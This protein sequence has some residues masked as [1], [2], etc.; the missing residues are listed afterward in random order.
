M[1]DERRLRRVLEV[2]RTVV[3]EL[4]LEVVLRRV[5]EVA[6]ELTDAR[7]AALGV[8][9]ADKRELE[10]FI[11]AGASEAMRQE[12]GDLPRG[13]GVLGVLIR[14]PQSLR[15]TDVSAHPRSYGFPAGHPPMRSF[16]GVPVLVRGEAYGNLYLTDKQGADAFDADDQ[17]AIELLASWAGIAID[18]ARAYASEQRR[19]VELEQAVRA[20]EATTAIARALGGETDVDRILEL[21]VKRARA[22][23]D[24]RNVALLLI[25][26]DALHVRACAGPI[27]EAVRDVT[28]PVEGSIGGEVVRS[29]RSQRIADV[30][31]RLRFA[32]AERVDADTGLLVP[33]VFRGR[34]LGVLEA[35]DREDGADFSADD[36]HLLVSFAASAATAVATA[37]TAANEA[38]R[39]SLLASERERTR[40]ARE[41]HDETLQQLAGVK[42]LLRGALRGGDV[43]AAIAQAVTQIDA[44]I[45][46]LR[47]LITDLRPAALDDLGLAAALESLLE[48]VQQT[49]GLHT[50]LRCDL[51]AAGQRLPAELEDGAYRIVQ[52]ALT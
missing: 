8:L 44:S 46:E 14:E 52:E 35:F 40:W 45:A 37:Q 36:E 19:R 2:G 17:E 25:E 30:R 24:A 41:L 18:N 15:L 21:I 11:T 27:A 22:L 5:L 29:M 34:A 13:R 42:L 49:A 48:R 43:D 33:L 20:L 47:R 23:L 9:D 1:L 28:V 4:D 32:L 31:S 6:Q 3:S 7:Y 16:L 10:R 38:L 26:G 50:H 51:G 12:V 39:R